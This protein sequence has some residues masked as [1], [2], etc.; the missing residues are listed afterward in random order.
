MGLSAVVVYSDKWCPRLS[1][2]KSLLFYLKPLT[3]TDNIIAL[4]T[5]PGLSAIAVIRL[6]GVDVIKLVNSFFKS[7][8]LEQQQSHT[9]S[10]GRLIDSQGKLLD[11]VVVALFKAPRSYTGED[12][13]EISCHGSPYI[14]N[15][16]LQNFLDSGEVRHAAP[17]RVHPARVFKWKI[18]FDRS[19]SH[20]GFNCGR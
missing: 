3:A 12:V 14:V 6:S 5:P 20:R 11:E 15:L 2:D 10:F 9:L 8:D 19:R 16:I 13:V 4:S 1:H 17:R 7:K 18:R